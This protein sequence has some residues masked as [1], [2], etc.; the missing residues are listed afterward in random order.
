MPFTLSH[1]AA[2]LP[3]LRAAG[4]RGPLVASAL[5]A[6]SMAPDVPFFAESL[7]P[8]AYGL[9]GATHSWWGVPTVDVAI[10]G[11]LVAGW[12][13]LLRGPLVGLLPDRL[14][15]AAEA[16]TARRRGTAARGAVDAAWFA[17]SAAL[18]A[19]THVGW[20]AFT[21]GGRLGVTLLPVLDRT[22]AGLPLYTVLQYGSSALA[23][24]ALAGYLV[25][26][27]RAVEPARPAV[28]LPAGVRRAAVAALGVATAAGVV[29]RLTP[30]RR[31]LIPEFCFGAGAGLAVGAV[32]YALVHAAVARR[33]RHGGTRP[34]GRERPAE[35][36]PV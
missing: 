16:L 14:A 29:Q 5:V 20:D 8:G 28:A 15:P 32:G 23:L 6:G 1:P 12:H 27:V 3:L 7:L 4:A 24:A 10:A 9:G 11:V 35:R 19:A 31:N 22:V 33:G 18:G 13:T 36:V 2:V 21:H 34:G 25:R 26:A 30:L 17:G